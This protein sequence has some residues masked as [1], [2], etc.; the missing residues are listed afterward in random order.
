MDLLSNITIT[1]GLV[2]GLGALYAF[3]RKGLGKSTIELLQIENEA[4]R[5]GRAD[6]KELI[7][8]LKAENKTLRD[9]NKQLKEL[10]QQTP[11]I[12]QLTEKITELAIIV[13][14]LANKGSLNDAKKRRSG[15]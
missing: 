4:L 11:E 6:D 3:F 5:I 9:A 1:I 10:A 7:A 14:K 2:L 13:G 8:A 12:R 15:N